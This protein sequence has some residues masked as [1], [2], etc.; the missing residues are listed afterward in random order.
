MCGEGQEGHLLRGGNTAMANLQLNAT[1]TM[2]QK[3]HAKSSKLVLVNERGHVIG[4]DHHRAVLSDHD[5][6][7]MLELRA[8]GYSYGWLAAKFEVGKTTARDICTGR[9]RGQVPTGTK[10][11]RCA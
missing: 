1:T 6:D 11:V 8:E 4:Q 5:I 3:L 2:S 10:R 9:R 7:L